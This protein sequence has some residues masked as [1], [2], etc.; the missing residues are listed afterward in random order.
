MPGKPPP[1]PWVTSPRP[2][3][4]PSLRLFCLPFSGAGASAYIPWSADLPETIE[5]CPIQLPGRETRMSEAPFQR[6]T[7][8][9]QALATAIVPWLDLPF[10][11]F[12]HSLGALIGYELAREFRRRKLPG[13]RYLFASGRRAP[14]IVDPDPL[15]RLS[16][17]DFIARLRRMDGTPEAI[18]REPELLAL[19]LPIL[20]ADLAVNEAEVH[21][22]EAAL[23]CPITAFGGLTDERAPREGIEAW[24]QHTSGPFSTEMFPGGHFFLRS[25][26]VDLLQSITRQLAR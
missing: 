21:V 11:V 24:R 9:V 16:D 2:R 5:V 1:N 14:H 23:D 6:L 18:L 13:P 26:R 19:F 17:T 8:L 12:G 10:A 3:P 20:R 22:P 4:N 7:P 15:H 25:S